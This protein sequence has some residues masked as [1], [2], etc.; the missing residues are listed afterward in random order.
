MELER[1]EMALTLKIAKDG[2]TKPT[3]RSKS[4]LLNL[5]RSESMYMEGC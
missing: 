5:A 4:V 2:A 3:L 1:E